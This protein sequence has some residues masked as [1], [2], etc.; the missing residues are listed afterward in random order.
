MQRWNLKV[1]VYILNI[2]NNFH[3]C[4][5]NAKIP[6]FRGAETCLPIT[7]NGAAVGL[8]LTLVHLSV[9]CRSLAVTCRL[10]AVPLPLIL[11]YVSVMTLIEKYDFLTIV[12]DSM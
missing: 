1:S 10:S 5:I 2:K 8:L 9:T 12:V 4:K 3:H 6:S 11:G 7:R